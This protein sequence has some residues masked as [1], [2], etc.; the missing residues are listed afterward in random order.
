MNER[1]VIKGQANEKT[2]F[3]HVLLRQRRYR[4]IDQLVLTNSVWPRRCLEKRGFRRLVGGS[5]ARNP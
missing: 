2:G 3:K 4:P 5:K 1:L